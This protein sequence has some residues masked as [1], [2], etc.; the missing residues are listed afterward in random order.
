MLLT[1]EGFIVILLFSHVVKTV[2]KS[3]FHNPEW[4]HFIFTLLRMK[5]DKPYHLIGKN[6]WKQLLY[7]L[8]MCYSVRGGAAAT[9]RSKFSLLYS[10]TK[11]HWAAGEYIPA[12][13]DKSARR[14][15]P[16]LDFV[17]ISLYLFMLLPVRR[18]KLKWVLQKDSL[19]I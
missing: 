10:E 11:R 9:S 8:L 6:M 4:M 16:Y 7:I 14:P 13:H 19:M 2:Q 3:C 1:Q 5:T 18:I 17:S 15:Q 12:L